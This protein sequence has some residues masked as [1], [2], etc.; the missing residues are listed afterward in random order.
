MIWTWR[1]DVSGW[2]YWDGARWLSAALYTV[3]T[4]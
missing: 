3:R 4:F 2:Y 1:A